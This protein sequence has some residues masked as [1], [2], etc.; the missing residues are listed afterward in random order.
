MRANSY[1]VSEVMRSPDNLP[2]STINHTI[3]FNMEYFSYICFHSIGNIELRCISLLT[4][5]FS[6]I[7]IIVIITF[8][9]IT[10]AT[11]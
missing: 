11:S 1:M 3:T 8:I 6:P 2:A 10:I 7:I 9:V 5:L 4:V